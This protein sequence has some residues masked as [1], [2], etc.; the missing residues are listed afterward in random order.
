MSK[1]KSLIMFYLTGYILFI[2]S[3]MLKIETKSMI[4]AN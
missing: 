1:K 2:V 4:I 3:M